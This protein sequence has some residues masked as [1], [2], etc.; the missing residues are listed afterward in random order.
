MLRPVPGSGIHGWETEEEEDIWEVSLDQICLEAEEYVDHSIDPEMTIGELLEWRY[1]RAELEKEQVVV[2]V[3]RM[4]QITLIRARIVFVYI[5]GNV[6][7]KQGKYLKA[8]ERYQ[9]AHRLEPEMPHYRLNLAA[10]YLKTDEY[11]CL[12]LYK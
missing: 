6:A 3:C 10:A 11:V 7:F 2:F 12:F 1:L 8:I 9:L 4:K 5:Q